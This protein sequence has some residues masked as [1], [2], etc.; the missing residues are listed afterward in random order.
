M[1]SYSRG[2]SFDDLP[3]SVSQTPAIRGAL[4][5]GNANSNS[6]VE[7]DEEFRESPERSAGAGYTLCDSA[8]EALFTTYAKVGLFFRVSRIVCR[9]VV[10]ASFLI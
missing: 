8:A 2:G 6:E 5:S 4:G 9:V 10:L 1:P 7:F 3:V